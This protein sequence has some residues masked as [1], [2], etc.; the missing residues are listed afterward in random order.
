L[1]DIGFDIAPGEAL[2]IVG[3][4][5]CG[6]STLA[7]VLARVAAV[8]AGSIVFDGVEIATT[9]PRRAAAARW[10]GALQLLFQDVRASLDPLRRVRDALAASWQTNTAARARADR[11]ASLDDDIAAL[12]ARVALPLTLLD[13]RPHQLS[14]GEATRVGLARALA[15]RPRLLIL[16]E[17]T[18]SLDM[19]TQA[20][21]VRTIDTLRREHGMALL[22]ISHDLDLVRLLCA[23]V[24]VMDAGRI[25]EAGDCARVFRSPAHPVTRALLDARLRVGVAPTDVPL[26]PDAG[27]PTAGPT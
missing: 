13:R 12:A 24:L 3:S 16:D 22:F 21:I 1:D 25:V 7:H 9:G 27:V 26:S 19:T 6:K 14:G 11:G 20:E 10:R 18:A 17:P 5:G 23:R 4:S 2:G 8:D 15:G